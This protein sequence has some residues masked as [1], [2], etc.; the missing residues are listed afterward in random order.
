MQLHK[1]QP[2]ITP[3]NTSRI[4]EIPNSVLNVSVFLDLNQL[5]EID[6]I[7][8]SSH[9]ILYIISDDS[10]PSCLHPLRDDKK[11]FHVIVTLSK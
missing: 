4:S 1:Y 11:R 10:T 9:K 7:F 8:A 2:K 6:T 5:E 3:E